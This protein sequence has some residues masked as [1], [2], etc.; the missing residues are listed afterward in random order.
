MPCETLT[1]GKTTLG[2]TNWT[3]DTTASSPRKR[4]GLFHLLDL[5]LLSKR[6]HFPSSSLGRLPYYSQRRLRITLT[7]INPI[8]LSCRPRWKSKPTRSLISSHLHA[9]L[10]APLVQK[11][12]RKVQTIP[13]A[14]TE[15]V[16]IHETGFFF[17][18]AKYNPGS[19]L[20]LLQK[21]PISE[22]P[23]H[24]TSLDSVQPVIT[25]IHHPRH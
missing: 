10:R 15:E 19:T 5:S 11:E 7:S 14:E 24:Q 3:L 17:A 9:N 6:V 18:G 2:R 4:F 23:T 12:T 20:D 8:A 16:D 1:K 13:W 21:S 22:L 25:V